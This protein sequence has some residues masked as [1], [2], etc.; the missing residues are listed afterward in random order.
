[1]AKQKHQK[2]RPGLKT[3]P[4]RNP[5]STPE[6]SLPGLDIPALSRE[7]Q[8]RDLIEY[9]P[10][11][12]EALSRFF[13]FETHSLYFPKSAFF[14]PKWLPEERRLLLP[15]MREGR[16]LGVFAAGGV[17]IREDQL[18]LLVQAAGLC[19]D[20]LALFKAGLIESGSGLYFRDCLIHHLT[21][22]IETVRSSLSPAPLYADPAGI[23]NLA[24]PTAPA[25]PGQNSREHS[26]PDV[27][28][29]AAGLQ[30][31]LVNPLGNS[32]AVMS[33]NFSPMLKV[34]REYGHGFA[35]RFVA[36]LA[37]HF[38]AALPEHALPA[39]VGDNAFAV[40][41]PGKN[42]ADCLRMGREVSAALSQVQLDDTLTGS[43]VSLPVAVG[44]ACYPQDLDA[45]LA[46]TATRPGLEGAEEQA[47]RLLEKAD[48]AAS[49]AWEA[50]PIAE[51]EAGL[52]LLGFGE[53]LTRGGKVITSLP[54]SRVGI[55]L[56]AACGA[57]EG[58]HFRVLAPQREGPA[59]IIGE[60]VIAAVQENRSIAE[61]IGLSDP[62]R[63]V[64]PGDRLEL[65]AD[66]DLDAVQM[67]AAA[68]EAELAANLLGHRAFL[69]RFAEKRENCARFCLALLRLLPGEP[70]TDGAQ[71]QGK[72]KPENCPLWKT[73][74]EASIA[75]KAAGSILNDISD[76]LETGAFAAGYG[77]HSLMLFVPDLD[78]IALAARLKT[79]AQRLEQEQGV[80]LAAGVA[81]YPWL[82]YRKSEIMGN[83]DKALD[84]AL[85]LEK[86]K[87]G[88]VN[89]LA[90]NI[91][92]D[93]HFSHGDL[94]EAIQEYKQALLAD[95]DNVWAWTSL[96]VCLASIGS[97][98]E[99][100][101]AFE[102]AVNRKP[103]ELMA[104]YNLAQAAQAEGDQIQASAY[105]ERCLELEPEHVFSLLRL[106]QL[107]EQRGETETAENYYRRAGNCPQG[108]GPAYRQLARLALAA[109]RPDTA[110]EY[111]HRT[112]AA[113]PQDPAALAL[114]A[115]IY[116]N[117]GDNPEIALSLVRQSVALRPDYA[118]AWLGLS[119]ACAACGLTEQAERAALRAAEL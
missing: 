104:L 110:R 19:L 10:R 105:Y 82:N 17:E 53:I 34:E 113:N 3:R 37:R 39:R 38:R 65:L 56:G 8:P 46:L 5:R 52:H 59:Q 63:P 116:L 101:R 7:L 27:K 83:A 25:D 50:S 22:A 76:L 21:A 30:R 24:A 33:V 84:F 102:N 15:L 2:Q 58:Y 97:R 11:L 90:L 36:E 60:I 71:T 42:P 55:N 64:R 12:K 100:R 47:R 28:P 68:P 31:L 51:R 43:L 81:G 41:L 61:V 88:E 108:E 69:S 1:M 49:R 23:N 115:E 13:R 18:E 40:Y 70:G 14:A 79:A 112:L 6:P 44:F 114:L 54:M 73:G 35:D 118:Q 72:H 119:R 57:R 4:G 20:N 77:L 99:A 78:P 48:L 96:G 32:F 107:A 75:A 103:D 67:F 66:F 85:L 74:T 89:S 45:G 9:E 91:R 95:P 87:I 109:R 29:A 93:R 106:G 92:A 16:L 86:P 62:A 117:Q 80:Q 26:D 94:F 111:L 98:E